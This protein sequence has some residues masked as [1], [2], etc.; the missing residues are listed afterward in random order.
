MLEQISGKNRAHFTIHI[1]FVQLTYMDKSYEM[2]L[3][4]IRKIAHCHIYF[5]VCGGP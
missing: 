4:T 3:Q 5:C 2:W 1:F